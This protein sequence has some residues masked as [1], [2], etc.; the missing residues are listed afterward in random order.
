MLTP[1]CTGYVFSYQR[2]SLPQICNDSNIHAC[3][4]ACVHAADSHVANSCTRL[5]TL[6]CRFDDLLPTYW[7]GKQ[8]WFMHTRII[9]LYV[10]IHPYI[11]SYACLSSCV[12]VPFGCI[13]CT[14][15]SPS[16][17]LV[18]FLV[19]RTH[20][21]GTQKIPRCMFPVNSHTSKHKID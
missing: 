11:H 18:W 20:K 14:N 10:R 19:L 17:P 9:C 4:H 21:R 8:V 13:V 5:K 12:C 1:E 16:K 15:Q 2:D 7:D 6:F 3:M